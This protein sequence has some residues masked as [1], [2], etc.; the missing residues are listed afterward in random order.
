VVLSTGAPTSIGRALE[1]AVVLAHERVSRRHALLSFRRDGWFVVDQGS[2]EGTFVNGVAIVARRPTPVGPGD[3][4][5]IGPWV[6]RLVAVRPSR[7]CT[8]GGA[9]QGDDDGTSIVTDDAPGTAGL[10]EKAARDGGGI[11]AVAAHRLRILTDCIGELGNVGDEGAIARALVH[12]AAAACGAV[13]AVLLRAVGARA[14][15][16]EVIAAAGTAAG[17]GV[18]GGGGGG[19]GGG[20]AFSRSLIHTASE[21]GPAVL[22]RQDA[23]G[24]VSLA[25]SGVHSAL[26][27]PVLIGGA[28]VAYLYVDA[29]EDQ[30]PLPADAAAFC[31]AL[32]RAGGL[33]WA[34][35]RRAQLERRQ[36]QLTDE[37]EAARAAQRLFLPEESGTAACLRYA[38]RMAPGA[39]V[40]GDLFDAVVQPDGR[41]AVW[42]GDVSGHG[43]GSAMLMACA[44]SH[45]HGAIARGADA[46]EAARTLNAYLCG[47]ALGG[48][49]VSLWAGVVSA[50]GLVRF[51]DA[52]HGHWMVVGDGS[53][54]PGASG[55]GSAPKGIPLGID[56]EVRIETGELRLTPGQ[57]L[58]VYSDGAVE[59]RNGAGEFFGKARLAAAIHP[60]GDAES[61]VRS[62]FDAILAFAGGSV[63]D[64]DVTVASLEVPARP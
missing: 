23:A 11:G 2:K 60:A 9:G 10:V 57:R 42:L 43:A 63:L 26:C 44:Q 33:A 32:A 50:D 61:D 4:L 5:R 51:A 48:R 62:A 30:P 25:G 14:E 12:S 56:A 59:E 7:A 45:L 1:S 18:S 49:F 22:A 47:R 16:V 21:G 13:R 40:A 54:A 35:L 52:G 8:P 53:A 17:A 39:F 15:R 41:V 19:G 6:L 28:P 64:D 24:L 36:R 20:G 58:V 46:I 29:R 31:E 37:L 3:L 55:A 38:M 34:N 27:T